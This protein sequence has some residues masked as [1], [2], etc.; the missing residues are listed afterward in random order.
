[1]SAKLFGP[2]LVRLAHG[3]NVTRDTNLIKYKDKQGDRQSAKI[4][5]TTN[6]VVCTSLMT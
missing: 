5:T 1:M 2:L 3:D 4:R 6:I